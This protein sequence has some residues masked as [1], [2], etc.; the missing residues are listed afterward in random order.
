MNLSGGLLK[1]NCFD[2]FL[3]GF[4]CTVTKTITMK[5]YLKNMSQHSSGDSEQCP[6]LTEPKLFINSPLTVPFIFCVDWNSKMAV[7][8]GQILT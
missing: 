7:I 4:K 3:M 8:V 1:K 6:H 2:D 5:S